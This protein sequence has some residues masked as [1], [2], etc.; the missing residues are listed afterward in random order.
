[1]TT[2]DDSVAIKE[3]DDNKS[4]PVIKLI[5]DIVKNK[6]Y[7]FKF[8]FSGFIISV[9][10]CLLLPNIYRSRALILPSQQDQSFTNSLLMQMGGVAGVASDMFGGVTQ[11]E[12]FAGILKSEEIKDAIIDRFKLLKVYDKKYRIE[13]YKALDEAV[14]ITVGKKDSIVSIA[15]EDVDPN[16]AAAMANAFVN[17]LEKL[18]IRMST[19]GASLNKAYLAE[20]LSKSKQDLIQA[21]DAYAK[22]QTANKVLDIGEQAKGTIK[23]IADL[24]AQ[25]MALEV[26]L[27]TLRRQ[28]TESSQEVK[29]TKQ[30]IAAVTARIIQ[31][32]G[33][34]GLSAIPKVGAVP[35][36]VQEFAKLMRDVKVQE[37]LV[38]LL[39]KQYEVANLTEQKNVASVQQVQVARAPDKKAKPPRFLI[40]A[41]MTLM[42][43]MAALFSLMLR[44]KYQCL[45]DEIKDIIVDSKKH[46]FI[47]RVKR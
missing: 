15:V 10:I 37:S 44:E 14:T 36:V 13:A 5:I 22:F 30:S 40:V 42:S 45:P 3:R 17:E 9:I 39:A 8:T 38:E 41:G 2:S 6:R 34:D 18:M 26:Q 47:F 1:M 21:E 32:E 43:F 24:V 29:N 19:R 16:R 46:L 12:M 31:Q 11:S 20:R 25:K 23:G 4:Y 7:V 27:A 35:S 33:K 28:F